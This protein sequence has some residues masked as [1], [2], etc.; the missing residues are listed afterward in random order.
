MIDNGHAS[1][2]QQ[3]RKTLYERRDKRPACSWSARNS[4]SLSP[5]GC[6]SL[7]AA[8][9]REDRFGI[10]PCKWRETSLS[11]FHLTRFLHANRIPLRSKTL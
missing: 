1:M 7:G 8:R 3:D 6:R 10:A 9:R 5:L 4:G 2:I 11:P